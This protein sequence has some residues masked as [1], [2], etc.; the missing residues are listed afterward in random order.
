MALLV[1]ANVREG[2]GQA[3]DQAVIWFPSGVAVAGLWLLGAREWW[4]VALCTFVQRLLLGYDAGVASSGAAGSVAEAL[5]GA[6]LLDGLGFDAAFARLR[7]FL[8]LLLAASVAPAASILA[9]WIGRSYLWLHPSMAFYSGWGGWWRMNALGILAVVPPLVT[10]L[11]ASAE[12]LRGR[13]AA[14]AAL[15]AAVTASA[16]LGLMHLLPVSITGVLLL[17]VVLPVSLYAGVRFGP[18]GAST[19]GA[20]VAIAVALGTSYGAGPFLAVARTERHA[21]LQ[22]FELLLV[23]VPLVLGVLVAESESARIREAESEELLSSIQRA[24]PDVTYRIRRDYV[25]S[26]LYLPDGAVAPGPGQRIVG[27]DLRELL[28]AETADLLERT[29]AKVFASRAPVTVDYPLFVDGRRAVYEARCVP[30][31]RDEILAVVRDITERKREEEALRDSHGLLE[32]RVAE[33][34]ASLLE[35]NQELEA[36]SYSVSHE[37]RAPLRA[38]DG[39]AAL[40]VRDHQGPLEG[41]E[42]RH[43]ARLRWNA[44]RMGQLIDDLLVFA[45][46]GRTDLSFG[47]VDMTGAAK[48]AFSRVVPDPEPQARIFLSVGDLPPA[49]GDAALL[50]RV[51]EN[52]L[53]NAVK[54]S[55]GRERPEIHVEGSAEG[56]E[57]TYRVR[58]NGVGFDMK[59]V[60]KLFG[61]FHRLHGLHEFEGTGVG[62]AL[63]RRIV[64]RHGGS[65]RAEGELD[66]GATFFF[67]LPIKRA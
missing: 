15:A 50:H 18:R 24:L 64:V 40:I 55:A 13:R 21:A 17:V 14:A 36:F 7:D 38:I 2:D 34:T 31:G 33:R 19:T 42:S 22:V 32:R 23:T 11:A 58:D 56:D 59:Y 43:F 44:Q 54:F 67:S 29:V 62:L 37:L 4:L 27:R 66:R 10:W 39:H 46:A 16:T 25:C 45:H 8:A 20:L 5:A 52:L 1:S 49:S 3:I 61:V 28:P 47:Q 48:G 51:W 6:F 63:V 30:Y 41:E 12:P 35:A 53:S 65:V 26:D 57:A 60:D 9:S